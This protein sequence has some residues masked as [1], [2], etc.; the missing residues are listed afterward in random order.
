LY[1]E[2]ISY[3]FFHKQLGMILFHELPDDVL[4]VILQQADLNTLFVLRL[5]CKPLHDLIQIYISSI[6]PAVVR[7]TFQNTAPLLLRRPQRYDIKWLAELV[8]RYLAT[9]IIDRYGLNHEGDDVGER[10]YLRIPAIVNEGEEFREHAANG[11]KVMMRLSLISKEVHG[12][13]RDTAFSEYRE[14]K[15]AIRKSSVSWGTS[16]SLK[17]KTRE[18]VV[19]RPLLSQHHYA[20]R[21]KP[22]SE[23]KEDSKRVKTVEKLEAVILQRRK[24][25]LLSIPDRDIEDFRMMFPIFTACFRTNTNGTPYPQGFSPDFFDLGGGCDSRG[26]RIN[27]GHSWVNW[28]ILHE[29]PLLFWRQWCPPSLYD[30][31]RSLL[32]RRRLLQAWD[33]RG[34]KQIEAETATVQQ[35]ERFL[36]KKTGAVVTGGRPGRATDPLPYFYRYLTDENGEEKPSEELD[37]EETLD[38]IPYF[39]D[40]RGDPG[41]RGVK[42]GEAE[43]DE[44][45][46]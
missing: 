46:S 9:V 25:Y 5:V 34:Y 40:F 1:W 31:D 10:I 45:G 41:L 33:Q 43:N 42:V 24:E 35:L 28:F 16:K 32:I 18:L 15:D 37:V 8:P 20:P 17:S 30:D 23:Q 19:L 22:K 44:C 6:A 4:C 14:M 3:Y 12:A 27:S 11:F 29:G 13:P 36:R 7:N 38:D 39:I 2:D 26:N 21:R